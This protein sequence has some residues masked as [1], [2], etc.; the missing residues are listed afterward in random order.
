MGK[1]PYWILELMWYLYILIM[2]PMMWW[3]AIVDDG[4]T[5]FIMG[6]L[7]T[8]VLLLIPQILRGK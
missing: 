7:V 6:L 5:G 3:N 4:F 2:A 8:G 1:S